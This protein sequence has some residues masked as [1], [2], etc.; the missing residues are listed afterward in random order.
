MSS[1]TFK[2]AVDGSTMEPQTKRSKT[3]VPP[4]TI[5]TRSRAIPG[6]ETG[7]S[8]TPARP[9]GE[10]CQA[11]TSPMQ[12]QTSRDSNSPEG[13]SREQCGAII[14]FEQQGIDSITSHCVLLV[15]C[16]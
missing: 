13:I 10:N 6:N 8:D 2:Q 3:V 15:S 7:A 1:T 11:D 5:T 12:N 14:N 9:D 16:R 4:S